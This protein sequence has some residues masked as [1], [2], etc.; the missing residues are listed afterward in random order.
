MSEKSLLLEE[1]TYKIIGICMAVHRE[2]GHGF[3]EIV[4][5]DAI[6]H[7]FLTRQ[8]VYEREK[9]YKI[10]YKGIILPHHFFADFIIVDQVILEVKAAE[11]GIGDA[12]IAQTLNYLKA[13][14]CRLGL[15]VNFG[16]LRLEHKRLIL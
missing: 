13:S 8:V 1:E 2:L 5:K 10:S 7:E 4:Y 11:G 14:G 9:E 12:Y 15:L 6:E 16:R 3:M